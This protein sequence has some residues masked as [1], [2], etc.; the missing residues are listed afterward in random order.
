MH[1]DFDLAQYQAQLAAMPYVEN[2]RGSPRDSLARLIEEI[3]RLREDLGHARAWARFHL[4]DARRER[5]RRMVPIG[6]KKPT[7]APEQCPGLRAGAAWRS[8]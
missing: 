5:K 6:R 7:A 4:E 8:P 2:D 1:S 3:V